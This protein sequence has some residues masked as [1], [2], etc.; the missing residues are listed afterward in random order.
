MAKDEKRLKKPPREKQV[1][2]HPLTLREAIKGLGKVKPK[3]AKKK[4]VKKPKK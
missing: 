2:L 4:T 1:S 3:K